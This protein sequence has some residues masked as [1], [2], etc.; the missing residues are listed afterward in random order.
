MVADFIHF[1]AWL[2]PQRIAEIMVLLSIRYTKAS[3]APVA[4]VC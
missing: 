2:C 1:V 3:E 4:W